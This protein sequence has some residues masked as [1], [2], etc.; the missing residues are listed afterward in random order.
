MKNGE[1]ENLKI[2]VEQAYKK[3]KNNT[4]FDKTMAVLKAQIALFEG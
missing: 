2:Y 3:L 1:I 4:Y